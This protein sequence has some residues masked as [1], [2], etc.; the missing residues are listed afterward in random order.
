VRESSISLNGRN[1]KAWGFGIGGRFGYN[2]MDE[3]ASH[4]KHRFN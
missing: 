3:L 1:I 2:Q 4:F